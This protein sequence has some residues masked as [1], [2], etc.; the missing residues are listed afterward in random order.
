[1]ADFDIVRFH[2]PALC[3]SILQNLL[4]CPGFLLVVFQGALDVRE[5]ILQIGNGPPDCCFADHRSLEAS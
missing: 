4:P 1:M 3:V 2:N 5:C